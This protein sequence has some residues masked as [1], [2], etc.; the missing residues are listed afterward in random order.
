VVVLSA[1]H[2][3]LLFI[4]LTSTGNITKNQILQFVT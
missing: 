2:T 4:N 1:L 3:M